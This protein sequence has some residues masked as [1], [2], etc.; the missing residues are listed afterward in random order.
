MGVIGDD[1][2]LQSLDPQLVKM[3]NSIMPYYTIL[4]FFCFQS[5]D[6]TTSSE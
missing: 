2:V 3:A 4:I 1:E 6:L 5:S